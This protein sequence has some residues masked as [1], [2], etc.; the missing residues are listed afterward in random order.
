MGLDSIGEVGQDGK[1]S[2]NL[3]LFCCCYKKNNLSSGR[4][5][6]DCTLLEAVVLKANILDINYHNKSYEFVVLPMR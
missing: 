4:T 3:T 6:S 5:F 1:M 2:A